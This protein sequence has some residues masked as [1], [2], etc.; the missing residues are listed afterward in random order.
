MASG[1]G[2]RSLSQ[3]LEE[4]L[5]CRPDE[6]LR[7][8]LF[9]LAIDC[10]AAGMTQSDTAT[11]FARAHTTWKTL[12][13]LGEKDVRLLPLE[14]V[15][16]VICGFEDSP[17]P[18]FGQTLQERPV[19]VRDRDF[20]TVSR[21]AATSAV[22]EYDRN[23]FDLTERQALLQRELSRLEREEQEETEKLSGDDGDNCQH[24]QRDIQ[25]AEERNRCLRRQLVEATEEEFEEFEA[26]EALIC[27][28]ERVETIQD[29]W[30][31]R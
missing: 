11:M 21:R 3:R 29:A 4:R 22:R 30:P 7:E 12:E 24:L 20:L 16:A 23:I 18:L 8:D 27:E 14:D 13:Q 31:A 15:L 25:Q 19:V 5:L 2:Q 17:S 9:A 26:A 28:E 6:A 1:T 10:H